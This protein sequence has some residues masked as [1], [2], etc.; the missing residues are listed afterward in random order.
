ML[1]DG[2]V[3]ALSYLRFNENPVVEVWACV[4]DGHS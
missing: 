3:I 2:G 1:R 4:G